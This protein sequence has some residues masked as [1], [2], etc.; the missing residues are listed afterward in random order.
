MTGAPQRAT[1]TRLAAGSLGLLGVLT[2]PRLLARLITSDG[3]LDPPLLETTLWVVSALLVATAVALLVAAPAV[4]ARIETGLARLLLIGVSVGT[5]AVLGE[6]GLRVWTGLPRESRVEGLEFSYRARTNSDGFRDEE[7]VRERTPGTLRVLV[8]GDSFIYGTG[9]AAEDSIPVLLESSLSARVGRP[10]EVYN[11]GIP[12]TDTYDYLRRARRFSDYRP[13]LVLYA[14][15]VD[16]DIEPSPPPARIPHFLKH[17]EL[18]ELAKRVRDRVTGSACQEPQGVEPGS[19]D[20]AYVKLACQ[21]RINAHLFQRAAVGDN[22]AYYEAL[23]ERFRSLPYTKRNILDVRHVFD[24]AAF[25]LVILP[26]KY[27]VS[28]GYFAELRKLGFVFSRDEPVSDALQQ[29]ICEWAEQESLPAL[30]ILPG[31]VADPGT[32][33]YYAIDDHL[34]AAGNQR[35][36]ALISDWIAQQGMLAR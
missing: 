27:Q 10:V 13:D 18:V 24:G 33:H 6:I 29:A 19:I 21:G 23:T 9:V 30:D 12:G 28:A 34:N 32:S 20:P 35:T 5:M 7:F 26:S 36:A 1:R 2:F 14:L 16:N 4:R 31:L 22:H 8:L 3:Q 25:G 15:Y 11:L 17:L